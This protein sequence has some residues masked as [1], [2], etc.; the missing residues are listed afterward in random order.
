MSKNDQQNRQGTGGIGSAENTGRDR[1][2]QRANLRGKDKA[3]KGDAT[4]TGNLRD[5]GALSGR[6]DASGGSG[7]GMENT[8]SNEPTER[9]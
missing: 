2:E 4:P 5:T 6:D 7:D 9:S 3:Q 8:S 1:S